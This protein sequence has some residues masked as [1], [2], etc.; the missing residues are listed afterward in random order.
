M[1]QAFQ[2]ELSGQLKNQTALR[3]GETTFDHGV[4]QTKEEIHCSSVFFGTTSRCHRS[5]FPSVVKYLQLWLL[6]RVLHVIRA[7]RSCSP[8]RQ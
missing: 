7:G 4:G 3:L 2:T 1:L 6:R 5:R 8:V